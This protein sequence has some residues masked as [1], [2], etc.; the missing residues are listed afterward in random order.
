MKYV[1]LAIFLAVLGSL[2]SLAANSDGVQDSV[3]TI[4]R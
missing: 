1:F 4:S 3:A 2:A